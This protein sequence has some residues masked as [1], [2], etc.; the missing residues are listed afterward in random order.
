[1]PYKKSVQNANRAIQKRMG[2]D[3]IYRLTNVGNVDTNFK[4][5]EDNTSYK[6]YFLISTFGNDRHITI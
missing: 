5:K 6:E 1:M 4:Q 2:E 3:E